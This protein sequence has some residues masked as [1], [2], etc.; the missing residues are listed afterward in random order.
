MKRMLL[1][2]TAVALFWLV[3]VSLVN[4]TPK[5]EAWSISGHEI[6]VSRACRLFPGQWGDFFRYYE[7]LLNDTVAYPDTFYKARDPTESPRHFV[8]LEIWNESRPETGT[9]PFA[10]EQ[11]GRSMLS[12]IQ[13]RDWNRVLLDA[14]RLAHYI[15]DICQPYHSTVNYDPPTKSGTRQHVVLDGAIRDHLTEIVFISSVGAPQI[16]NFKDYAFALAKQSQSFLTEINNT[17]IDQNMPWSPRLTE[18]IENRT[19]TAIVATINVWHT[20]VLASNVAAPKLPETKILRIVAKSILQTIDVSHD[21]SFEFI[22]VDSLGVRTPCEIQTEIG[23]IALETESYQEP[24]NPFIDYRIPLPTSKLKNLQ[25]TVELA[26]TALRPGYA[27]VRL[28]VPL[29]VEGQVTIEPRPS[30]Q[31]NYMIYVSI[32]ATIIMLLSSILL[33]QE[34]RKQR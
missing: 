22:V 1:A 29:Q 8:D 19:N 27:P 12:A 3:S 20:A 14:G 5:T 23:G 25:V 17:L 10:V 18:I 26:V 11:F 9:L 24:E 28:M 16:V 21:N 6:I 7:W 13:V 32:A 31:P 34:Y 15:S 30:V 33:L 4:T 2:R